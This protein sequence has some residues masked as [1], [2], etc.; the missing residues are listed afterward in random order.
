MANKYPR[1]KLASDGANF[2]PGQPVITPK[3]GRA[4][5]INRFQEWETNGWV[6]GLDAFK[7]ALIVERNSGDVNRM[8]WLLRP[9]LMNQ[10]RIG[11]TKLQFI[12]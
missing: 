4:E 8:D 5:A 9:N 2:G 12:L 10:F 1:H 7:E 3:V 6:E 11:A